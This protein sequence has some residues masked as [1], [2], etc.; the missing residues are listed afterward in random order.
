MQI[1]ARLVCSLA[2]GA[3]AVL[4]TACNPSAPAADPYDVGKMDLK[5]VPAKVSVRM[6]VLNVGPSKTSSFPRTNRSWRIAAD[7]SA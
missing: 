1:A 2:S 6:H 7:R 3:A 4:L 5:P